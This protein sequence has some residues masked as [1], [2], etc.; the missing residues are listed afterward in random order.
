MDFDLFA[1]GSSAADDS[2]VPTLR[3]L[4]GG[5]L[6]LNAAAHRLL[7]GTAFVQLLWDADTDSIGIMPSA[8]SD[9]DSHRVAVASAQAII[10]SQ[11]FIDAYDISPSHGLPMLWDGRTLIAATHR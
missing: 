6:V 11:E 7:G 10:T 3:I 4:A 8:E 9:P 1:P 2:D 5:R